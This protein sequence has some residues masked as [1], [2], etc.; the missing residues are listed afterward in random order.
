MWM[1]GP[2][3]AIHSWLCSTGSTFK[4]QFSMDLHKEDLSHVYPEE[5]KKVP[6]N[7]WLHCI[8]IH[9]VRSNPTVRWLGLWALRELHQIFMCIVYKHVYGY[10]TEVSQERPP[11][12]LHCLFY[13]AMLQSVM[14]KHKDNCSPEEFESIVNGGFNSS[15]P[16]PIRG[17]ICFTDPWV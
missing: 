1:C 9:Y 13:S 6:I 14:D 15:A 2:S 7:Q 5:M 11:N 17:H 10:L 4:L 8:P 12:G 16:R 3:F